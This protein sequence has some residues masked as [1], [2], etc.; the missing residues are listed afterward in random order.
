M[1]EK[2]YNQLR[3][4]QKGKNDFAPAENA[5]ASCISDQNLEQEAALTP[6]G[7]SGNLREPPGT[8]KNIK[9]QY[10]NLNKTYL[11]CFLHHVYKYKQKYIFFGVVNVDAARLLAAPLA[12][13]CFLNCFL[14]R[15]IESCVGSHLCA[16][17]HMLPSVV[18]SQFIF[19][20]VV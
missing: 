20:P 19:F 14:N 3:N 5:A 10:L 4:F 1:T 18:C 17:L 12:S 15:S 16:R 8:L 13:C 9:S 6:A 2:S 11:K 7:T